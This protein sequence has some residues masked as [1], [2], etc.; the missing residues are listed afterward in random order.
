MYLCFLLPASSLA[1]PRLFLFHLLSYLV[2]RISEPV[3][4]PHASLSALTPG[5]RGEDAV[6][7]APANV[8]SLL[9]IRWWEVALNKRAPNPN[10]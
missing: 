7:A 3:R 1:S 6:A 8:S 2:S 4:R 5:V 9:T 10:V